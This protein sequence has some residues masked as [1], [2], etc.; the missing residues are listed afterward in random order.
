MK[1][2]ITIDPYRAIGQVDPNIYGQFMCR[3]RWV[4]DEALYAP[5]HPDADE[6][7][8]RKT[9]A[10]YIKDSAPPVLR[11]PGGCTGTTYDWRE[12]IGPQSERE[13]TI[14]VHFGYDVGN[15]FGTAEFVEFCRSIGAEPHINVSTGFGTLQDAVEWLEY[16]NYAGDSKYA[17]LRRAHGYDEPFNVRYW[18]IGNENY[19]PWEIGNHTPK[20][21]AV[22]AR[23]WA[24]T[25]KK[26]DRDL[27]VLVVGGSQ[28]ILDWDME[29]LNEAWPYIDYITAHRYWNFNSAKNVENYDMIAG[30]GHFEEQTMKAIAGQI[31]LVAREK[32]IRRRPRLAFT[33][34]GVRDVCHAEMT[35]QWQPDRTQYR[36]VDALAAAGFINAMRRQC[37]LVGLASFAQ[38]INV[39]GMLS[40]TDDSVVRET[41][42]WALLMQRLYSGDTSV[43]AWVDCDGYTA[44]V[45]HSVSDDPIPYLDVSATTDEANGKL[46]V[47]VVNRHRDEEIT[48]RLRM[49]DVAPGST[50]TVRR[51]WHEDPVA[52]NTHDA[53]D[54]ITP[55][56]STLEGV[57][58]DFEISLPPHSFTI[59]EFD[60]KA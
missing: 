45:E 24:K 7:G 5:D 22:I 4:A 17:N 47:S 2:S 10:Q 28:K 55:T 1:A 48:T 37:D 54:N 15:G 34:W 60:V 12:G 36:M 20:E 32:K 13:R 38:S 23:E 58:G 42:Y 40:V 30:V 59:Y 35:A 39:V 8:L 49:R 44:K 50:A 51:L 33:E 18:Q 11:W 43:D 57:S 27:K 21:Y 41:L 26:M 16:C 14:D 31:D 3:R 46:F 29:V 53:P 9:V 25:I 6:R 19:G 56:E 52:M